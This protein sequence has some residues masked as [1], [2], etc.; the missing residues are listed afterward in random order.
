MAE[1]IWNGVVIA[2]SDEYEVVEGNV[3][4]PSTAVDPAFLRESTHSTFCGWKGEASF[5]DVVV[6]GEI[7]IGLR[8][9]GQY[10]TSRI[11]RPVASGR[12]PR[13]MVSTSGNSGIC[14]C[15]CCAELGE[16]VLVAGHVAG[17]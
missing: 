5:Y 7:S 9:H 13:T 1:A 3:Y 4:L 10:S 15:N 6:D 17:V 11:S 8:S 12:M 14:F 16:Q 2:R